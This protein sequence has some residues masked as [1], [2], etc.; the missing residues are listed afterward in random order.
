MKP[1]V[2]LIL[3]VF[4]VLPVFA[5][6]TE[7]QKEA[8]KKTFPWI[9]DGDAAFRYETLSTEQVHAYCGKQ[10]G[11][12]SVWYEEYKKR[13]GEIEEREL[14][15]NEKR[16]ENGMFSGMRALQQLN[17]TFYINKRAAEGWKLIGASQDFLIFEKPE[18]DKEKE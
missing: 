15:E 2:R 7:E 12:M 6:D 14:P 10:Q 13:Y 17:V 8:L 1:L 11:E 18:K 4:L 16:P 9:F 3:L 5:E